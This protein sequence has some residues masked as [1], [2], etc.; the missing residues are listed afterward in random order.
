MTI[1]PRAIR[2]LLGVR[3]RMRDAA[4]A[5]HASA[6]NDR[7]AA[8]ASLASEHARLANHLDVAHD[9]LARARTIHAFD[10]VAAIT[11][12]HRLAIADA[13]AQCA[14]TAEIAERAA[15]LLRQRTRALRTAEKLLELSI[16]QRTRVEDRAE[17]R[18][19]DDLGARRKAMP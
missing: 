14:A 9:E 13:N 5:T 18:G 16:D 2:A 19:N 8:D 15:E 11:T 4:A 17:Q 10:Q 12:M 1:R 7:E 3:E 6:T